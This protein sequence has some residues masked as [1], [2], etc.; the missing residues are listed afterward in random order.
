MSDP[1]SFQYFLADH[2]L[3]VTP[4]SRQWQ[5]FLPCHINPESDPSKRDSRFSIKYGD[6]FRAACAFL[7]QNRFSLLC[8]FVSSRLGRDITADQLKAI[9]IY[10]VK[11][12]QYY[13]PARVVVYVEDRRVCF[14]LN[15]AVS[16]DGENLID[17][18][19]GIL[20]QLNTGN[21]Y[22]FLPEVYFAG[23][24]QTPN[25]RVLKMFL[26]EW[27]EGY[28]EFHLSRRD[29]TGNLRIK[30]WDGQDPPLY[31]GDSQTFQL[32][33]MTAMILTAYFDLETFA[34][35]FPWHH[36][37]GDFVIKVLDEKID[38]K[39]VSVRHYRSMFKDNEVIESTIGPEDG[40]SDVLL[41]FF[42][43]LSLRTRLD[44]LDGVGE[45]VWSTD[46]AVEATVEGFFQGLE[47]I[48]MKNGLPLEVGNQV[49]RY[50]ASYSHEDLHGLLGKIFQTYSPGAYKEDMV[51]PQLNHHALRLHQVLNTL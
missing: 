30:V 48:L 33:R 11:H 21:P 20:D 5:A 29:D 26:G 46:M 3:P 9:D 28:C 39:L 12:G 42:L 47:L 14:V 34:T 15:V 40:L 23:Q 10:L 18:E 17:G 49:R 13:H 22:R 8:R 51:Q 35:I 50:F 16:K 24:G 2:R 31:L 19:Y 6:Y 4:Q 1:F 41:I 38:L 37:S 25:G 27:L 44:R 45:L 43:N 36:A 32:Y 7:S